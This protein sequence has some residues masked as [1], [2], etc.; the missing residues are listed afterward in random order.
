MSEQ[1]TIVEK[2]YFVICDAI[3]LLRHIKILLL[4][5]L[6][7]LI[8]IFWQATI[9]VITPHKKEEEQ[10]LSTRAHLIYSLMPMVAHTKKTA[11]HTPIQWMEAN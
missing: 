5:L 2:Y 3:E 10:H 11:M 1:K 6:P 4:L 7:F 8:L 9:L